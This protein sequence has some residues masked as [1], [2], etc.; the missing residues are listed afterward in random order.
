[1]TFIQKFVLTVL[2]KSWGHAIQNESQH[3]L[4]RCPSCDAVLSVWDMGGI[5]FKAVSTGKRVRV[6]CLQCKQVQTMPMEYQK[7]P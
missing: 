6:R 4:L 3:W 2:P 5:R 1:M 7:S